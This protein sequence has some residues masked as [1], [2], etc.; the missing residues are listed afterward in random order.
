MKKLIEIDKTISNNNVL[1][2]ITQSIANHRD[3][4]TTNKQ[5]ENNESMIVE[6]D[7]QK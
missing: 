2:D 6:F 5:I 1:A 7:T 4:N 3:N